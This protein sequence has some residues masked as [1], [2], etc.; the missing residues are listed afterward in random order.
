MTTSLFALTCQETIPKSMV[1]QPR[2]NMVSKLCLMPARR[3]K[4]KKLE[5]ILRAVITPQCEL[6]STL[7]TRSKTQ[8]LLKPALNTLH[9]AMA[10]LVLNIQ[11]R[12]RFLKNLCQPLKPRI[13]AER[14]LIDKRQQPTSQFTTKPILTRINFPQQPVPNLNQ[15]EVL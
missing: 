8:V 6:I 1:T 10:R 15:E 14:Q 9:L 5:V 4:P 7:T 13:N 3:M 11:L 12:R 2:L